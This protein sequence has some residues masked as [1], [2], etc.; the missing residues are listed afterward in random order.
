MKLSALVLGFLPIACAAPG[1]APS[2]ATP[3]APG[4]PDLALPA[5]RHLAHLRPLTAGGENAEAY[6]AWGGDQ[7][8][9][10]ARPAGAACDRIF[11]LPLPA[12]S[13]PAGGALPA[14]VPVSDGKG[15]TTCSYFLP[16]D[17]E[18]IFASTEGGGPTCPPRPDHSQGYVWALYPSYDIYRANADGSGARRL[19]ITDGYDAE[20]T[21]CG[22]DG[23]IVFT[24]VRDGDIDLYRMDA[25]GGNVRRLTS[26]AGYDGGA[27]FDADCTHIVWRASRPRPGPE[28]DDYRRLL[29]QNLVR[30]S[31]LELYVANADGSEPMQITYLDAAS[32]GPAWM[33]G[34][35]RVIFASNYGDPHGREFDLWG[36]DVAGTRLERITAAPGFD[37]FP[38][39]SPDG[40]RLVFSSNRITAPGQH[41]T[42]VFLADWTEVPVQPSVELAADRVLADISWLADPA[43]MGRGVGTAGL[44]VAGAYIEERFRKLGLEPAGDGGGFR[45][46]FPVRTGI[47]V[48]AATSLR[49]AGADVARES[50]EPAGFSAS[51]KVAGKLVLA[52]HGVR[53]EAAKIDDYARLDVKDKIVVVRRFVPDHPAFANP[54]RQRRA[55]DLRQKA[56]LAREH[57]ARALLIVDAPVRPAS[58]P[59][60]WRAPEEAALPRPRPE[61]H[62]DAGIPVLVVKRAALAPALADL[63]RGKPVAVA[64]EVA[65]GFTTQPAFNVVGRLRATGPTR[66]PG[67]VV[68]GAHYDHLGLGDHHS[69][70]P[71]SR[72]PHLGAD[73]NASGTATVLEVA[74]ALAARAGSLARDVVFVTFSGEE[75]GVLGST[76]FTRTPP[77]GLAMTEVR[78]MINL[79]MVGRLRDNRA[80]ILGAASANEWPALLAD[81][82]AEA[83]I[84]CTPSTTG[85][86]GPSD[87]MPFY[88]AGVPVAHFFTGSHSDYHKPSDS[89]DRIN[90][91][92]AAQIG[93]AVA[94]LAA[95]VAA[96]AES[97]TLQRLTGPT[98]EGDA[99]SFN[100]SLGSIPDY[101]G[102]P[103]GQTGVLLAGVRPGGAAEKAGLRRGDLLTRLGTHPIG[104]VE[105]LMYALNASKPGETVTAVV[106]R[107]GKEL[108]LDVTFQEGRTR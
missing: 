81:A 88:A 78:A 45:Q 102:P 16:G 92:G 83:R 101:S 103:A 75:E 48:E 89:A 56:W 37:G 19:T 73:D 54:D 58:A 62:G 60:D 26:G 35:R 87:Q 77:A 11:R 74:R 53:D 44:D 21:V 93:V 66:A 79:D 3:A 91:A 57:G 39:F 17:R 46:A 97:L 99:R 94:A 38:L 6:W 51:G 18:V 76:H 104:S 96:R 86:F 61:G 14:P 85:G 52:G 9:M 50:F 49:V 90:A 71:G 10:Q 5:E 12:R 15:A 67:V 98:P 30:P 40:K 106:K 23:S 108:R 32:F 95:R 1:P 47:S 105:D 63:A 20:G 68:V 4:A 7:L 27:F 31:K 8:V 64:L 100:A 69:L 80:T 65:L 34:G 42:N 107:D 2:P 59:A 84:D 29:A 25:D 55:G 36:V 28:L 70:S 72:L 43:R 82:C 41:D 22:K 24:S 13:P 33:P